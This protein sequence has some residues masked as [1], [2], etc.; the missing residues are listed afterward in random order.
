MVQLNAVQVGAGFSKPRTNLLLC[1][2]T[3]SSPWEVYVDEDLRCTSGDAVSSRMFTGSS[4]SGWQQ[5]NPPQP[6]YGDV[7]Y[8]IVCALEWLSSPLRDLLPA[9]PPAATAP[10]G[11]LDP[12]LERVGRVLGLEQLASNVEPTAAQGDAIVRIAETVLRREAPRCP[13]V[14]GPPGC[15]KSMVMRLA[16]GGLLSRGAVGRV[17]EINGAAICSGA[18][19]WPERDERLRLTLE[20]AL[21]PPA[22]LVL[23]EQFELAIARSETALALLADALDRG[24]RLVGVARAEFTP[25]QWRRAPAL[26]RRVELVRIGEPEPAEVRRIVRLRL[27]QHPAAKRFEIAPDVLPG[28]LALA[29]RRPGGNPGAAL[30]LLEAVLSHAAWTGQKAIGPDD[31]FHLASVDDGEG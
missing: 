2:R 8:A 16:A 19:F 22:A 5:L 21:V 7:N 6:V 29:A 23:L 4:R 12:Y 20:A 27:D 9:A 11:S 25:A 13:V 31:V 28:V 10:L 18:I 1:R 26:A 17:I 3:T 14:V 15:G 30:G 24:L